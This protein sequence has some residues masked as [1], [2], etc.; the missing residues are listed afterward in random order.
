MKSK[1]KEVAKAKVFNPYD[2]V[3]NLID[4]IE[5]DFSLSSTAMDKDERRLSVGM[6]MYDLILGGGLVGGAWYTILGAEQ[7]AK[8]TD[9][10]MIMTEAL[11]SFVPIISHWDYEG[12]TRPDYLENIMITNGITIPVEEVF[13]VR[14]D[15]GLWV[16]EPRVRYYSEIIAEKFFDFVAK[17]ERALPDKVKINNEWW[18]VYEDTKRN[19]ALVGTDYDH[20]YYK[21]TGLI[22]TPSPDGNMQALVFT[23][24]YPAMLPKDS[25]VDD[26]NNSIALQAR[27]FSRQLQRVKGRMRSKK[28]TVVGVNQLRAKPM[29]RFG[30]MEEEPGGNA[31]KLY[32][33][34]RIKKTSRVIPKG[35]GKGI[36]LQE[37]A[38][39]GD[40]VDTYRFVH[41][42]AIKNKLSQPNLE[43]WFRIWV[44]DSDGVAR[45][46]D[47]VWDTYQ[48]LVHTG[49]IEGKLASGKQLKLNLGPNKF[50]SKQLT[51][52]QFKQ[53]IL[54]SR[55]VM[56]KVLKKVGIEKPM[57]IREYCKRQLADRNGLDLYYQHKREMAK[58][59]GSLDE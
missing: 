30:P 45:G 25:D 56:E 47:P 57:N 9:I 2:T 7:S 32:S 54:G 33:D 28:I 43:A 58:T 40:G 41:A 46:L 36:V 29:A 55:A 16:V 35:F 22:R 50:R 5:K 8:S 44:S 37:D 24:S 23:D 11:N 4:S 26:P 31:L 48:Y 21:K 59:R 51:W 18:Y 17:L 3:T 10:S 27:M 38:A 6:L 15:K 14:D 39:F 53:L 49:Q 12:S 34:C 19:K 42:R 52:N 1:S 20:K 13:G